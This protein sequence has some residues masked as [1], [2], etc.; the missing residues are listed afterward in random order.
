MKN[1][2]IGLTVLI[3]ITSFGQGEPKLTMYWNNYTLFNPANTGL[4]Y[5]HYFNTSYRNQ[6]NNLIDAP[7]VIIGQYSFKVDKINSG[8]GIGVALDKIGHSTSKKYYFNYAYHIN[9]NNDATL[10]LGAS[11]TLHTIETPIFITPNTTT[12]ASLD[13]LIPAPQVHQT[14]VSFNIGSIFKKDKLELGLSLTQVN[15]PYFSKIHVKSGMYLFGMA[16]YQFEISDFL[17]Y[18]PSIFIKSN[19]S[20]SD[21]GII[22]QLCY[23][24]TYWFGINY[25]TSNALSVNI[26]ADLFK[27]YR[28]GYAFE[29][30]MQSPYY[31][32]PSHE[33]TLGFLFK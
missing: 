31:K 5:K 9:L 27:K 2:L 16:S 23:D 17:T 6:W 25:Y 18:K 11:T 20:I 29:Y 12:D 19:L 1:I 13:P 32:Y 33:F 26:G 28:I 3:S 7:K 24:D 15:Q 8:V 22:N 30:N 10:S 21:I 14:K 4:N